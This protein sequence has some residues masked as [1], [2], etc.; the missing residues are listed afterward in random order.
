VSASR[1]DRLAIAGIAL[2]AVVITWPLLVTPFGIPPK[3]TFLGLDLAMY[4]GFGGAA[5]ETLLRFGQFPLRSPW[6]GGG[7]PI[8]VNPD[9]MILT[10]TMPL[11]LAAGPWAAMKIDFVLTVIA[12]GL[13]MFLL[14]RRMMGYPLVAA[15]MSATAFAFG[16]FLLTKWLLGW[17]P[18]FHAAWLP[19]IL[20]ALWRG[21]C[22][23]TA[24]VAVPLSPDN[25]L[26]RRR[27]QRLP[28]NPCEGRRRWLVLAAVLVAWLILDH[29]YVAMAMGWFLFMVGLLQLD[30]GETAGKRGS[31]PLRQRGLAPSPLAWGY[32]GRLFAVW[33]FG[34]G[35]AAV[36][37]IPMWPVVRDHVR[38]EPP[39]PWA[40][41]WWRPVLVW[42]VI[43]AALG[44]TP[45]LARRVRERKGKGVRPL[46][47]RGADP[48]PLF[49]GALGIAGVLAAVLLAVAFWAPP[50]QLSAADARL[51]VAKIFDRT[52]SFGTWQMN[53][54]GISTP[55]S[56][57]GFGDRFDDRFRSRAPVGPM[58]AVLAVVAVILRPRKTWKW[59]VLGGLFLSFELG[60]ALPRDLAL[61]WGRLPLL[62][63]IR[64]PREP[65]NF[66]WF[67]LLTL[68]AGRALD[69]PASLRRFRVCRF[70]TWLLLAANVVFLGW[71]GFTRYTYSVS[72]ALPESAPWGRYELLDRRGDR[73][74]QRPAFL[75]RSNV[76]LIGWDL[77]L[78]DHRH[79]ALVPSR[80][81]NDDGTDRPCPAFKDMVWFHDPDNRVDTW[82]F[83]PNEITVGVRVRRP[84]VL[85]INQINDPDWRLSEGVLVPDDPLLKVR[86]TRTGTYEV[87]LRYVPRLL[88]VGLGVS[89]LTALVGGLVLVAAAR[90]DRRFSRRSDR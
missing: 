1:A 77:D 24:V 81:A 22:W 76:G 39:N 88:F 47:R 57:R 30:A 61:S 19:L 60:P 89:A 56:S 43:F 74:R 55:C 26:A 65:L 83:T 10:P 38:N 6:H 78:N 11:I 73:W 63:W 16:G 36:K 72:D 71:I 66:Y 21:R 25:S 17:R 87:R 27:P 90:R 7:Y 13:G 62:S 31:D 53:E 49:V 58:V 84:D 51:H 28:H 67:F 42:L 50:R 14:T 75:L 40:D 29:K 45:L 4:Y 80:S 33:G 64:R 9:D 32:F 69:L 46:R 18:V 15:L 44:L 34:A 3:D 52:V 5:R 68:L 48:F 41:Q 85:V 20:Y 37:L 59:A 82:A 12:A 79:E 86:L 35:L 54:L 2:A 8:Y 23:R 70:G